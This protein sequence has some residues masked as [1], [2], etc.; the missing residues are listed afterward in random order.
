[1]V[2]TSS[3]TAASSVVVAALS[4]TAV[5]RRCVLVGMMLAAHQ[6][7][8]EAHTATAGSDAALRCASSR[9]YNTAEKKGKALE[10]AEG[11]IIR[12]TR[13]QRSKRCPSFLVKL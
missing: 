5:A 11:L 13:R 9:A 12:Y 7:A 3:T 10:K 2:V 8:A 4:G 6:L 1:M